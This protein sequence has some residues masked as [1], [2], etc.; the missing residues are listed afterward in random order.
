MTS[1]VGRYDSLTF[2]GEGLDSVGSVEQLS[3]QMGVAEPLLP[4]RKASGGV[5]L[6]RKY[7][8]LGFGYIPLW[9]ECLPLSSQDR[10]SGPPDW[11][12]VCVN[13]AAGLIMGV[14]EALGGIVSAS[15]VFSSSEFPEISAMLPFGINMTL[16]TMTVGVLWY[17]VFGRLQ[18]GYGTQQDLICILQANLAANAARQLAQDPK[19]IPATVFAIIC[20]SAVLTGA[21]SIIVGKLGWGTVML[22]IPKPVVNG[23]LGAIGVVVLQ[24]G[25]STAS[26]VKFHQFQPTMSWYDFCSSSDRL[27]QLG[28]MFG[29]MFCIRM[30][31]KILHCLLS[32]VSPKARETLNK[33][34]GLA[35]QLFPLAIFYMVMGAYGVSMDTLAERGWTYPNNRS[36]EPSDLWTTYTFADVDF[37]AVKTVL[38][39][40]DVIA[41]VAMAVLCT[42]LGALAITGRFPIGPDGDPTPMDPLDF[43]IELTTVGAAS[44]VLGLTGGN[45]IFHKFSVIQLR[46]DG[47]T[48]RIAVFMIAA[49]AGSLFLSGFP[50]GA[51][52]PKWF[53]GGL[54]MNTGWSFLKRTLLSYQWLAAFNWRGIRL[55]SPQYCIS[56]CCVLAAVWHPPTMAIIVGLV[57][58]I[59]LFVLDGISVSPVINVLDGN[60]VVSRTKRP[61]WERRVLGRE[62]DRIRLLYLQG[63]LFFGS[64][65]QLTANLAA[66]VAHDRVQFCILSFARVTHVDPS[67]ADNLK[68]AADKMRKRGCHVIYCRMR[69]EVFESFCAAEMVTAPNIAF[70]GQIKDMGWHYTAPQTKDGTYG[71]GAAEKHPDAFSHETDALD[72]CDDYIVKKFCYHSPHPEAMLEPYMIKYGEAV[73]FPG[74]RLPESSFEMMND[75][76]SGVMGRVRDFCE[77]RINE[78]AWAN[79]SDDLPNMD[80]ALCFIFKGA[81]SIVQMFPLVDKPNLLEPCSNFTFRKGKRLLKRY[82]P[83]HVAGMSTFF[84][85]HD[86]VVDRELQPKLIVSSHLGAPAEI[87]V[88]RYEAWNGIQGWKQMPDDLKGYLARMLCVQFADS[89]LHSNLQER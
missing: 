32:S 64:A 84:Q 33:F 45:L 5:A 50:I 10:A 35:C 88:L 74:S 85:F 9:S 3:E 15:M 53:L 36:S 38:A 46:E 27:G 62:G 71:E 89:D 30:G 78:L 48:H 66:V 8:F 82:P 76:P 39:S 22:M 47:G 26:G 4:T 80:R 44:V 43:N 51:Y 61:F 13:V 20:L 55:V 41:L 77:V 81:V 34:A 72:Y 1:P 25:L 59:F 18:Y 58:S 14:R 63:Q 83:G 7:H 49:C 86:Q 28:C 57:L 21:I 56:T 6:V 11:G 68:T 23:F 40:M 17:A 54:F 67:A 2:D 65:Y 19:K 79:L 37:N 52:V 60:R 42:V 24:A 12:A 29:H 69:K 87:W 75:L 31:P 16:Y 73:C 70:L